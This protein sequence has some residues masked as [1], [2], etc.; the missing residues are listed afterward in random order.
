M[1]TRY[2]ME[3]P[4]RL[5]AEFT[6][7]AKEAELSKAEILRKALQ[8]YIVTHRAV[9]NGD[10]VGIVDPTKAGALKTEFIGL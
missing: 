10:K 8:L 4:D 6:E 1:S 2:N 9:R 3:L 7:V 5:N